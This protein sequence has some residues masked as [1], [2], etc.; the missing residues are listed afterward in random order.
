MKRYQ[1][2]FS[3][4][5][6]T[7]LFSLSAL[8]LYRERAVLKAKFDDIA[9]PKAASELKSY[10]RQ[11]DG[12]LSQTLVGGHR[13]NELYGT[14]YRAIGKNEENS[15]KYVRDKDSVLYAGNFYNT[16]NLS[17]PGIAGRMRRLQD[18][19]KDKGTKLVVIMYPTKYREDWSR[20]YYGIP[21]NNF[22][23]YGDEVLRYLRRYDV[24]Y[25]DVRDVFREADMKATEI[26]YRTDHHWTVPSAFYATGKIVDHL[27]RKDDANLDPDGFYRDL[28]NYTIETYGNVY[29]GSQGRDAG[30]L[31]SGELDDY[32]FIFP[33]FDTQYRYYCRYRGGREGSAEGDME[34]A[35]I[36]RKYLNKK[37]LYDREMNNGY[38]QGVVRFDQIDNKLN[39]DGPSALFIRDSYSSPG[40]TFLSPMF[41]RIELLWSLHYNPSG[42]G[43]IQEMLESKHFDYVFVAL[44]LDN[45]TNEGT[46]FY[47]EDPKAA[48]TGDEDVVGQGKDPAAQ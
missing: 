24:D 15:F 19:L 33:K 1:A 34:Q 14:V 9:R 27:N 38:I 43:S 39:P 10:T 23:A 48:E 18:S 26:F 7:G 6:L 25:I 21:Y 35:L 44:A 31:Y 29:M 42:K 16:S 40:A 4:L 5:F 20:G 13:W 11:L 32:S 28:N 22:N 37:D 8:N 30:Q 47:I 12:V 2:V 46:P 41:S 45:F 3:A 17:A 36:S